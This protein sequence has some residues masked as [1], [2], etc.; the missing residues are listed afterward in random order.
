MNRYG[1]CR[2]TLVRTV[3]IVWYA[4]TQN[5]LDRVWHIEPLTVEN[6]AHNPHHTV[7]L[8]CINIITLF[9]ELLQHHMYAS[10]I[11]VRYP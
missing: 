11:T 8:V 2:S 4:V 7:I 1:H 9:G 5:K 3:R 10:T 6:L